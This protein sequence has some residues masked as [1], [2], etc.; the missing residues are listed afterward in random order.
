MQQLVTQHFCSYSSDKGYTL[1]TCVFSRNFAFLAGP[2]RSSLS[3]ALLLPKMQ[4]IVLWRVHEL[5][6]SRILRGRSKL[7]AGISPEPGPGFEWGTVTKWCDVTFSA[8]FRHISAH[9]KFDVTLPGFVINSKKF[10]GTWYKYTDFVTSSHHFP[11]FSL[12]QNI[13]SKLGQVLSSDHLHTIKF[14]PDSDM[15][16]PYYYQNFIP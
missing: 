7:Q 15:L 9:S 5:E 12:E 8:H 1:L 16:F 10:P 3:S 6:N 13:V 11:G 14:I 4:E 2:W